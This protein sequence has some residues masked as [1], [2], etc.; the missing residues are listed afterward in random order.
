MNGNAKVCAITSIIL[1]SELGKLYRVV[2]GLNEAERVSRRLAIQ[3]LTKLGQL[4]S[5]DNDS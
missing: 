3:I 2:A 1:A 4:S 5:S